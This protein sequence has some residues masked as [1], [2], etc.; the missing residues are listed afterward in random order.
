MSDACIPDRH[1]Q[2]RNTSRPASMADPL[3]RPFALRLHLC[4]RSASGSSTALLLEKRFSAKPRQCALAGAIRD[5]QLTVNTGPFKRLC[6]HRLR[7]SGRASSFFFG[8]LSTCKQLVFLRQTFLADLLEPQRQFLNVH[9][10]CPQSYSSPS[11]SSSI[12]DP[13]NSSSSASSSATFTPSTLR[14]HQHLNPAFR[15]LELRLAGV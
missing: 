1:P 5:R 3:S 10:P 11:S 9:F 6:L 8:K 15:L 4:G 14:L 7:E 2:A 13:A 12:P